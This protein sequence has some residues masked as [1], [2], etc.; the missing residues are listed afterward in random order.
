MSYKCINEV[1]IK[2]LFFLIS[3]FIF[4]TWH[5][6]RFWRKLCD[7]SL[8]FEILRRLNALCTALWC[9]PNVVHAFSIVETSPETRESQS[10]VDRDENYALFLS[11][12]RYFDGETLFSLH[13]TCRTQCA[14]IPASKLAE[15]LAILNHSSILKNFMCYFS[16]FW[17]ISTFKRS[18]HCN[19][20]LVRSARVFQ[21]RIKPKNS[22][23]VMNHWF[24]L[25]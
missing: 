11:R 15:K 8:P 4:F 21:L 23:I 13:F 20:H 19:F 18:F 3:F 5:I 2:F 1:K 14:G 25:Q 10:F 24:W 22:Q 6:R 12:L 16:P 17:Y 7:I 9:V